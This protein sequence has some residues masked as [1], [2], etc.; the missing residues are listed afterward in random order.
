MKIIQTNF[1][2]EISSNHHRD[3]S[4]C[5]RFIE[6]AAE[7]GCNEIKFQLFNIDEIFS[8]EIIC[9]SETHRNRWEWELP[10]SFLPE[11]KQCCVEN[12]ILFSCTPFYLSAV[13]ELRPYADVYKIASYELMWDDLLT[14]CEE[15]NLPITLP[16]GM[17]TMDE[18]DHAVNVLLSEREAFHG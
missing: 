12:K 14:T 2:A 18:I 3:I 17:T 4:R 8:P 5:F 6:T 16:T 11:L 10:V 13:D 7:I 15:T 1:I 9:Q